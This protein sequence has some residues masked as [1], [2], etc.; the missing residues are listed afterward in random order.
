MFEMR[1]G[2]GWHNGNMWLRYITN[3]VV[4]LRCGKYVSEMWLIYVSK[5]SAICLRCVWDM[6]EMYLSVSE[7]CLMYVWDVSKM[8]LTCF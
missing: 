8:F 4:C 2:C 5:V 6:F 7:M 1:L 3:D